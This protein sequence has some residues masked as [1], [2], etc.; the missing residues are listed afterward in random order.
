[1]NTPCKSITAV[2]LLAAWLP[3]AGSALA[4]EGGKATNKGT[5]ASVSDDDL[6][7]AGD[8]IRETGQKLQADIQEALRKARA[9][10]AVLEAKQAAERKQEA[11][12]ARQQAARDAAELAAAKEAK[13]RQV[14]L[15]AQAQ[16]KKE[17]EERA[18]KAEQERLAA[19]KVQRELEAKLAREHQAVKEKSSKSSSGTSKLG[20]EAS[21]G[22][23]I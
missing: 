12:K 15:A 9:Q 2:A 1:M 18:A 14:L 23:D 21:F 5:S 7:A 20:E 4:A 10:R 17:A 13:Q 22:V 11:E 19:V 16:A 8:R 3:L 6:K